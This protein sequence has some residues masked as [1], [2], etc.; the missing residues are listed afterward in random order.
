MALPMELMQS[1]SLAQVTN[2]RASGD[3]ASGANFNIGP[4]ALLWSAL[5]LKPSKDNFWTWFN[6]P[7]PPHIHHYGGDHN[8]TEVHAMIALLSNGPVGIS[9]RSGFSN[10]T[11]IMR[12]CNAD[13][14][15]LQPIRTIT[16]MDDQFVYDVF[17]AKSINIWSTE[18]GPSDG[19]TNA[20]ICGHIVLAINMKQ[21]YDL[22]YESFAPAL[23]GDFMTIIRNWY[24]YAKC[25][26]GVWAMQS[27]CVKRVDA[28]SDVLYSLS[29]QPVIPPMLQSFELLHVIPGV[30]NTSIVFLGELDKY[31]SVP[32]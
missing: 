16:A 32:Q 3:Y 8:S 12:L 7:V 20:E 19:T 1:L 22:T 30:T 6:E 31:V 25:A 13:G 17:N 18:F 14:R 27:G 29:P 10:D 26:H 24:D 11:L 28:N 23:N 21:D 9:D 15:L 5:G 4:G 2:G